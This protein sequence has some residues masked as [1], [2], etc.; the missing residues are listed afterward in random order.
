MQ[1]IQ[2]MLN[3]HHHKNYIVGDWSKFD[4]YVPAWLIRDAFK[5]VFRHVR[6]DVVRDVDGKECSVNQAKTK[7]S[8]EA[9]VNY[10]MN[11]PVQL[12]SG[13]RLKKFGGVLSGSCFTNVID[14]VVN[15]LVTRYQNFNMPRDLPLDDL[16]LGDDSIVITE[17]LM[18][19]GPFTVMAEKLFSCT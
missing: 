15:A 9:M 14:G 19:M 4:N 12:T 18:D 2:E 16:C 1:Y 17:K 11:T 3:Y 6:K 5:M 10:F 7:R 8:W 13:E